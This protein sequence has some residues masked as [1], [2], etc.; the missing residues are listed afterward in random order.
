MRQIAANVGFMTHAVRMTGALTTVIPAAAALAGVFVAQLWNALQEKSRHEHEVSKLL[1]SERSRSIFQFLRTLNTAKDETRRILF[2]KHPADVLVAED[3]KIE[4]FWSA[5]Y[6]AYLEVSLLLPG[7][8]ERLAWCTLQ[9]AYIWRRKSILQGESVHGSDSRYETL[10]E[11]IRPWLE[12][13]AKQR[14]LNKLANS[15][16][17]M[18]SLADRLDEIGYELAEAGDYRAS[19]VNVKEAIELRRRLARKDAV[20][21]VSLVRSLDTLGSNLVHLGRNHDALAALNEAISLS[22][23][24]MPGQVDATSYAR[25]Q[26]LQRR[27]DE[28]TAIITL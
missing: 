19:F 14:R 10:T 18:L 21:N 4:H 13:T 2:E 5:A 9:S 22:K 6:E 15:P 25:L 20:Y 28:I 24:T 11:Q 16:R 7:Y 12:V 17:L 27:S 26:D 3:R 8:P 1:W 23:Q